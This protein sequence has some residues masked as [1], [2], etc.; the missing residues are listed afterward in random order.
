MLAVRNLKKHFAIRHNPLARFGRPDH[1]VRA[2]D[3][4]SFSLNH[5]EI[6]GI[7]GESGS[8]KTTLAK[9]IL[10]LYRPSEGDV[11]YLD[12][13]VLAMR[14]T[15]LKRFRRRVQPIFQDAD[16]TLDPRQKVSAILEEPLLIHQFGERSERKRL[17]SDVL[18]RVNLSPSLLVR[19]PSELSGGQRQRVAIA[20]ALLLEP[21]VLIADEPTSGL[22]P[23][24]A[25]QILNLLITLREKDGVTIV[26]ISHDLD[27]IGYSSDRIAVMYRGKIVEMVDGDHFERSV[28]HPY[29][30]FLMGRQTMTL[31]TGLPDTPHRVGHADD[32]GCGYVHACPHRLSICYRVPPKLKRV[33]DWLTVACH[34]AINGSDDAQP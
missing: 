24:V 11:F 8:G 10:R 20:R 14:K 13:N 19:H 5:G 22:D 21:E 26:F 4:V 25:A 16:S 2:V 34:I 33:N 29:T 28:Q 12:T 7:V 27:T 32:E 31:E 15:E 30:K 18:E 17:I 9:C 3:G 1:L 23:V 6:L